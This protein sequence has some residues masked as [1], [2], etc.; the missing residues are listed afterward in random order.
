MDSLL[1]PNQMARKKRTERE[2]GADREHMLGRRRFDA[3]VRQMGVDR[4]CKI[5]EEKETEKKRS[6]DRT[7]DNQFSAIAKEVVAETRPSFGFSRSLSEY[8]ATC[9]CGAEKRF[10]FKPANWTCGMCRK[11][12]QEE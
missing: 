9:D 8:V 10:V 12:H 11:T 6:R 5:Q 3:A 7:V 2:L 1:T 4:L